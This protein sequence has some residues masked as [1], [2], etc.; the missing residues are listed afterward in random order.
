MTNAEIEFRGL[1]VLRS[2]TWIS[3]LLFLALPSVSNAIQPDAE[4]RARYKQFGKQWATEDQQVRERL[5][6]LESVDAK[7]A[8]VQ[9]EDFADLVSI[10]HVNE[11][12]IREIHGQIFVLFHQLPNV[13]HVVSVQSEQLER[14]P[15]NHL[16]Q[17]LLSTE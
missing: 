15:F 8:S 16:E 5:A 1:R 6:A 13:R 9:C 14:P 4:Y 17:G 11:R 3:F 2:V 12:C 7:V 10:R